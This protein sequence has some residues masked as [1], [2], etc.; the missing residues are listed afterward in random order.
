ML[1]IDIK[2]I[3]FYQDGLQDGRKEGS[4]STLEKMVIGMLNFNVDIEIIHKVSGLSMEQI[5]NL[6]KVTTKS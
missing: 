3:P 2:D 5:E 6:K 1:A 4:R